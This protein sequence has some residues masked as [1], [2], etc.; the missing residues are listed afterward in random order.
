[1][2]I[3]EVDLNE[4][5]QKFPGGH[6]ALRDIKVMRVAFRSVLIEVVRS[7]AATSGGGLVVDV[8]AVICCHAVG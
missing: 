4:L 6:P 5:S 1:M 3:S 7:M 8:H 2:S